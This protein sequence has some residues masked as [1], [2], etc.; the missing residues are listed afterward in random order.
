MTYESRDG[1]QV[2]MLVISP[3]DG[4][5]LEPQ[6]TILYGYGGFGISMSPAYSA[7]WPDHPILLRR[8]PEVGHAARAV[9]RSAAL[10][11]DT[12]SFL[13]FHAGLSR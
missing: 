9:S 3:Q 10:S 13:A 4:Q 1:T 12:L 5:P 11:A 8:E 7:P 2:R 6:P